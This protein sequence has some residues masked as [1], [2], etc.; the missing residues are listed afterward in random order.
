MY[1]DDTDF[2]VKSGSE[3]PEE[4][5]YDFT[6]IRVGIPVGLAWRSSRWA[7]YGEYVILD[8]DVIAQYNSKS[9]L[10]YQDIFSAALGLRYYF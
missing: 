5:Y 3:F 1:T 7:V 9:E 8:T 4:E 2:F 10:A 6:A